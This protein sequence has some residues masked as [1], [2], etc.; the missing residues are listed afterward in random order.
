MW[1]TGNVNHDCPSFSG[2]DKFPG[3]EDSIRHVSDPTRDS[4]VVSPHQSICEV[5]S[6]TTV[7]YYYESMKRKLESYKDYIFLFAFEEK[8][9]HRQQG[10]PGWSSLDEA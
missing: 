5:N 1:T 3:T 4:A 10:R 7:Y 8:I 2:T 9:K 6:R